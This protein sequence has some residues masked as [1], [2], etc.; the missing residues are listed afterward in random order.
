[1]P[2]SLQCFTDCPPAHLSIQL[3]CAMEGR[4]APLLT[5]CTYTEY[6][7]TQRSIA[8]TMWEPPQQHRI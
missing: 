3:T 7:A 1:M 8:E 6:N 2:S 5:P 4:V